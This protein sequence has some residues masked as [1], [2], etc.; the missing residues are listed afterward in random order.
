ME[1][2]IQMQALKF[3]QMRVENGDRTA[4]E[5]MAHVFNRAV[6]AYRKAL[7]LFPKNIPKKSRSSS[8]DRIREPY[9][10]WFYAP[11]SDALY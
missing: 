9:P 10:L 4:R 6:V 3:I 2:R 1:G 5:N 11:R 7:K 8:T